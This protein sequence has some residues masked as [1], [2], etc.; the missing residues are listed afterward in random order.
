M[1]ASG[2]GKPK[3]HGASSAIIKKPEEHNIRTRV[4]KV[5]R[6]AH[7]LYPRALCSPGLAAALLSPLTAGKLRHHREAQQAAAVSSCSS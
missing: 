5:L 6:K 1:P 3:T 2:K 4:R 7:A